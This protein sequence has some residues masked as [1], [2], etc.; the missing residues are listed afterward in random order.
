MTPLL[1]ILYWL[2]RLWEPAHQTINK[3]IFKKNNSFRVPTCSAAIWNHVSAIMCN[4]FAWFRLVVL[5]A[6]K[7]SSNWM[8][9]GFGVIVW[10][11]SS[12]AWSSRRSVAVTALDCV[13]IKFRMPS[14]EYC[15]PW[16]Y[17]RHTKKCTDD[18]K[19]A[20]KKLAIFPLNFARI[21]PFIVVDV[22]TATTTQIERVDIWSNRMCSFTIIAQIEEISFRSK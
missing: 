22:A 6:T 5:T 11:A 20:S 2:R 21:D 10:P 3:T 13:R 12:L 17:G 7:M 1:S 4:R 8:V 19:S 15:A 14:V 9:V 16:I 18:E